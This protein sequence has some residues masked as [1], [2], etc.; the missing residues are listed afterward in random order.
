MLLQKVL[1]FFLGE[2]LHFK[3]TCAFFKTIVYIFLLIFSNK[4]K[5]ICFLDVD[6]WEFFVFLPHGLLKST[7]N[8]G[9]MKFLP[10]WMST[11]FPLHPMASDLW[12]ENGRENGGH[13]PPQG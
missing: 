13:Y 3:K 11:P 4:Q 1:V 2:L 9:P 12:S 7:V 10:P 6:F 5:Y 8:V